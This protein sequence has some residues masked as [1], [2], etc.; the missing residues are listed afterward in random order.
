MS[1]KFIT[2]HSSLKSTLQLSA[3]CNNSNMALTRAGEKRPASQTPYQIDPEQV[4]KASKALLDHLRTER[5]R[6]ERESV[7]KEL[8]KSDHLDSEDDADGDSETP[9]WLIIST[10]QH[11][12]DRN[13]LKP[14]R[15]SVPHSLHTSENLNICLITAD[16]QRGLKNVV[17]DPAFPS[18]LSSKI[19]KIIGFTKLKARYKTFESRRQLLAEHDLFLADDRI[20]NRLPDT[21]GKVFYKATTKRPIPIQI[22]AIEKV[23]GKKVKPSK[24]TKS[25]E[26]KVASFATPTQVAKEIE[27]SLG[28]I[29]INAKP[30]TQ[31]SMRVGLASFTPQQLKDNVSTVVNQVIEKHVARGWRNIKGIYV[32]SPSSMAI[33]LWL[34]DEIWVEDA[35]VGEVDEED[36]AEAIEGANAS[37]KRKRKPD[38]TSGPQAGQRKKTK[39]VDG[40]DEGLAMEAARKSKLAAQKAQT[41][42]SQAVAAF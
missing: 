3:L 2:G 7:K 42:A 40:T 1:Q 19:N 24:D 9:V 12:A 31:M 33:P 11:I 15:I 13:H 5:K 10:K 8:F 39:L 17:A 32:K 16:P 38:G 41:F 21:L 37:R 25:K 34:A 35:K 6:L 29:T 18:E 30:G 36:A 27:K 28:S 26:P 23:D 22:S 4:L 20:V 14:K